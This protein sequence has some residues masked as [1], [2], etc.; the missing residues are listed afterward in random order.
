MYI[1]VCNHHAGRKPEQMLSGTAQHIVIL[2]IRPSIC[3]QGHLPNKARQRQG[4]TA[5][6]G[7]PPFYDELRK[8]S[9][10]GRLR[11]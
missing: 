8:P 4:S 10:H 2:Q 3:V 9:G 7:S 5:K 6:K 11:C 1:I